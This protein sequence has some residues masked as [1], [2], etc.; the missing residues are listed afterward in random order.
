MFFGFGQ[1]FYTEKIVCRTSFGLFNDSRTRPPAVTC[2]VDR[3]LAERNEHISN[4][5]LN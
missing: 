1:T 5:V 2:D 4:I 3:L